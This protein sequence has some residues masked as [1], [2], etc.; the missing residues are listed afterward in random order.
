[1]GPEKRAKENLD[2]FVKGSVTYARSP[3]RLGTR[4][5]FWLQASMLKTPHPTHPGHHPVTLN[6]A[7]PDRR[8]TR[9]IRAKWL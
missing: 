4:C 6:A 1:M 5:L 2:V 7:H 3:E 8:A 9:R